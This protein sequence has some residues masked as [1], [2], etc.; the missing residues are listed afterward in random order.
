MGVRTGGKT[1]C[2]PKGGGKLKKSGKL[3]EAERM[4]RLA[5]VGGG[6]GCGGGC[7]GSEKKFW[8]REGQDSCD[9]QE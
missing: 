9:G 3:G 1:F 8:G 6:G 7:G 4:Y 5:L 2:G